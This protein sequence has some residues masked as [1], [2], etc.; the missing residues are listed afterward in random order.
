MYPFYFNKDQTPLYGVLHPADSD[1]Y[2]EEGVVICYPSGQEYE[3]SHRAMR[4]IANNLAQA[5]YEVLR[6]DYSGT[7]D[8]TGACDSVLLSRWQEDIL[9]AVRELQDSCDI[10]RVNL[11]GLRLGATL[12][13][14]CADKIPELNRCVAWDPILTGEHFFN[15]ILPFLDPQYVS[16]LNDPSSRDLVFLKGYEIPPELRDELRQLNLQASLEAM[17]ACY[18]ERLLINSDASS[19]RYDTMVSALQNKAAEMEYRLVP[20][21]GDWYGAVQNGRILIPQAVVQEITRYFR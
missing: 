18:G 9:S 12:A 19:N 10:E 21:E 15:D 11:V 13:L 6:F 1:D 17:S 8:S 5:G 7:G 3:R 20:S 4:N 14:Q 2:Q 16:A